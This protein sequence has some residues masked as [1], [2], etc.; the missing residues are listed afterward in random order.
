[1]LLSCGKTMYFNDK[2]KAVAYFAGL[3]SPCPELANPA[4]YFMSI[5]SYEKYDIEA[6][7]S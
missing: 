3:G 6:D 1:M 5:M 7:K 2:A 4:D